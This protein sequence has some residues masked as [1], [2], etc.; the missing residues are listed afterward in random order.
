MAWTFVSQDTLTP[1]GIHNMNYQKIACW[2]DSQTVGARTYGCY[3]LYLGQILNQRTRY[4]WQV[5]SLA[6]NGYT[7]RDLWL[8]VSADL[9]GLTDFHQACILIGA[10]DVGH[11]SPSDTFAEYYRQILLRAVMICCH[12]R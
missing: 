1:F 12:I 10:N 5:L 6:N 9:P 3:P 2:G 7:A 4:S 8:R 11:D